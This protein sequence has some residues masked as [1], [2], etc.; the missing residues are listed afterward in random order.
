[1]SGNYVLVVDYKLPA[2]RNSEIFISHQIVPCHGFK[3]LLFAPNRKSVSSAHM[4][5]PDRR[6]IYPL[7]TL[8]QMSSRHLRVH[9]LKLNFS[10]SPHL[11]RHLR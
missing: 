9:M 8:T 6:L 2:S 10:F 3:Y 4:T 1:M 11:H 7:S 5:T